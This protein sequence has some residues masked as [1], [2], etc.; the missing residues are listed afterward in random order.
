MTTTSL[1]LV[2]LDPNVLDDSREDLLEGVKAVDDAEPAYQEAKD[3]FEG[4]ASEFF[5]SPTAARRVRRGGEV[6]RVNVA[7]KAVTAVTDRL[8]IAAVSV[9]DNGEAT[10]R[11]L[12]EVWAPNELALEA[13]VIHENA[14]EYGDEYVFLTE[15]DDHSIVIE[16]SGALTTRIVYDPER[17]RRP[18]FGI[19]VWSEGTGDKKRRRANLYYPPDDEDGGRCEKWMTTP[20]NQGSSAEHWQPYTKD[21]E[22]WPVTDGLDERFPIYHFRTARPYGEPLH[23][24]AYG[25]QAGLNKL[26][27]TMMATVDQHGYPIRYALTDGTAEEG[28]ADAED[29]GDVLDWPERGT[30][31]EVYGDPSLHNKKLKAGPGHMWWLDGVKATGQ[32]S[33]A[34]MKTFLEPADWLLRMMATATDT[35]LHFYDPG[36]DQ[37]SGDS[38]RQAEGTLTKKVDHLELSFESTWNKIFTDALSILGVKVPRVDVR[39]VP[40]A[41]VDDSDFWTTAAAK[42]AA[43]VPVRQVLLEGGYDATTVDG[44]LVD[45]S[46]QDLAHKVMIMGQIATA[47]R[48]LGT[49]IGLGSMDAATV[50]AIM[51]KMII[52]DTAAQ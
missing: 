40:S 9:P 16:R 29:F 17:P 27:V 47:A 2:G 36:G 11:L 1:A 42:L 33:A 31:S 41:T 10:K 49:A 34:E 20:G 26:V 30:S 48:D 18:K 23:K 4:T 43:G 32:Y 45:S 7:K 15:E 28:D 38:R 3:F 46:E 14:C 5:A 39:W 35:P 52:E 37:P 13:P 6:F 51:S 25:P 50:Q 19:K 22:P 44:W 24:G 12:E 21:G 8:E